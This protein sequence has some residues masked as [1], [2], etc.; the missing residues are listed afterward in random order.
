MQTTMPVI[1]GALSNS[2]HSTMVFSSYF[3]LHLRWVSALRSITAPVLVRS[4]AMCLVCACHAMVLLIRVGKDLVAVVPTIVVSSQIRQVSL[5]FKGPIGNSAVHLQVTI[6]KSLPPSESVANMVASMERFSAALCI[7]ILVF[8]V[9]LPNFGI[10]ILI[11]VPIEIVAGTMTVMLLIVLAQT[12]CLISKVGQVAI[13]SH[14]HLT[15]VFAALQK[16]TLVDGLSS[17][18]RICPSLLWCGP[19]HKLSH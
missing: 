14:R 1:I 16:H 19:L 17:C 9:V 8:N 4:L 2:I 18:T 15:F 12:I 3:F 10:T 7:P 5:V 13:S 6:Q 11:A